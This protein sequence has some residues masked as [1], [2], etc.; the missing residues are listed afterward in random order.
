MSASCADA[1]DAENATGSATRKTMWA[2]SRLST[3][4]RSAT[5]P[6]WN[7]TVWA[8]NLSMRFPPSAY[9]IECNGG[10]SVSSPRSPWY[11]PISPAPRRVAILASRILPHQLSSISQE[12]LNHDYCHACRDLLDQ[13]GPCRAPILGGACFPAPSSAQ[14]CAGHRRMS[15]RRLA[16]LLVSR[17]GRTQLRRRGRLRRAQEARRERRGARRS[18]WPTRPAFPTATRA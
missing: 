7:I 3:D 5:A 15:E 16:G 12:I 18:S 4:P 1:P 6:S 13:P 14:P 17:L 2:R 8:R 9:R 10:G 11:H